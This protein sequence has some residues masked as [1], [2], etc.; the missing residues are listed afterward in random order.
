VVPPNYRDLVRSYLDLRW[1]LDPVAASQAGVRQHDPRLGEFSKPQVR[2]AL[3]A[4]KAMAAAFE[5]CETTSLAD[6]VDQTAVLNDIKPV[7]VKERPDQPV[8]ARAS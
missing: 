3:A 8:F 4:L 2:L 7:L 5:Y 1:Q 6:E